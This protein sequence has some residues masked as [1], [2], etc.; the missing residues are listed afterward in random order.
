M[1][2]YLIVYKKSEELL[3]KVYPKKKEVYN[4]LL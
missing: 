2:D 3:Y 4:D 1:L